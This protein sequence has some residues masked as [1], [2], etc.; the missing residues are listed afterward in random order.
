MRKAVALQAYLSQSPIFVQWL[1]CDAFYL[2][3][4]EVV[5]QSN[6]ADFL[7]PLQRLDDADEARVSQ[8]ARAEVKF[9]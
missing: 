7:I 6:L 5:A 2:L 4:K 8:P 3:T 9:I 1:Q